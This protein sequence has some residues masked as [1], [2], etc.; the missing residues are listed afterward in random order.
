MFGFNNLSVMSC[1][2]WFRSMAAVLLV[3]GLAGCQAG[4]SLSLTVPQFK[5]RAITNLP[6]APEIALAKT[7]QTAGQAEIGSVDVALGGGQTGQP[8]AVV[9]ALN[10][11]VKAKSSVDTAMA[12]QV[13]GPITVPT[14]RNSEKLKAN[15][16]VAK[17]EPAA[18]RR[19][20]QRRAATLESKPAVRKPNFFERAALR[21]SKYFHIVAKH[22][23]AQGVPVHLAM[24]IIEIESSFRPKATGK[25]GEVGLMQVRPRTA[26]GMGYKG[27]V[28]ALYDPDTNV[29][30]G[31]KYLAE[32]HRR[33][34]GKT[35]GTILKYNAGHYAKR[36]NPVSARYCRRVKKVMAKNASL[37]V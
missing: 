27:S 4:K 36:M 8:K 18:S 32:A 9:L 22:A 25:L 6:A 21:K 24:A 29:R 16:I 35:C 7:E 33:G 28:K 31:M 20:G 1:P 26:R 15:K 34:G 5:A 14:P 3:I 2:N 11:G 12:E 10:A 13:T 19:K 17:L 37:G 23:R 30:V